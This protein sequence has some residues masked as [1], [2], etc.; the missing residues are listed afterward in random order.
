[1]FQGSEE[2]FSVDPLPPKTSV[3]EAAHSVSYVTHSVPDRDV[4]SDRENLDQGDRDEEEMMPV[5]IEEDVSL[6]ALINF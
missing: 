6:L 4:T 2:I 1:M 5:D 3:D